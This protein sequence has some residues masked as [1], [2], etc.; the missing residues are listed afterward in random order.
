MEQVALVTGATSGIGK[1]VALRFAKEG[2]KVAV[3]NLN[4]EGAK[5]VA[6]EIKDL[7]GEA[8]AVQC[9]VVKK[10]RWLGRSKLLKKF[11]CD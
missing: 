10:N 2:A 1:A 4:L 7:G 3:V 8:I 6:E 5:R 9:D 11:W